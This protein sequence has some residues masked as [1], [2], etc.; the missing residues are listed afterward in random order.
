MNVSALGPITI[1]VMTAVTTAVMTVIGTIAAI[2]IVGIAPD[3]LHAVEAV[4]TTV[5]RLGPPLPGG[6]SMIKGLQGTMITGAG[7]MMTVEG[8]ILIM[9]DVGMIKTDAATIE[10]VTTRTIATMIGPDS[11]TVKDGLV[12]ECVRRSFAGK[13]DGIQWFLFLL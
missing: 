4:T 6:T 3:L 1:V 9:T 5:V 12:E 2:G 7:A 13:T 8:L 10:D 11:Q